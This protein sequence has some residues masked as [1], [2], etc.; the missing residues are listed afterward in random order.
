M[1][2]EHLP[3]AKQGL[4]FS[5]Q[6][7]REDREQ[8]EPRQLGASTVLGLAVDTSGL[9]FFAASDSRRFGGG[10]ETREGVF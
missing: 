7:E 8:L 2:R 3:R 10:S 1:Q 9:C 6:N 4:Y 5:S